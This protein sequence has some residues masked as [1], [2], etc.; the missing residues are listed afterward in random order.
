MLE[1]LKSLQRHR[2]VLFILLIFVFTIGSLAY[3][4]SHQLSLKDAESGESTLA[5]RQSQDS[6]QLVFNVKPTCQIGFTSNQDRGG[7]IWVREA[8]LAR[9]YVEVVDPVRVKVQTNTNAL[10]NVQYDLI[11]DNF[12]GFSLYPTELAVGAT[13]LNLSCTE[14]APVAECQGQ[15]LGSA[16][17]AVRLMLSAKAV[18]GVYPWPLSA[19]R[20]S[21]AVN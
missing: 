10:Y 19:G 4:Y 15:L 9:G 2:I 1:S 18:A 13:N 17:F 14:D 8:D 3:W 5:S 20:V 16:T 11:D 7:E 6:L 12:R 21:C